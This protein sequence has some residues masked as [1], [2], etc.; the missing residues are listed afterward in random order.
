MTSRRVLSP[1]SPTRARLHTRPHG[2]GTSTP[3]RKRAR[4]GPRACG[5]SGAAPSA[6]TRSEVLTRF[7]DTRCK[8]QRDRASASWQRGFSCGG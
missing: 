2:R 8:S 3:P 5:A 7:D 1:D 4:R 6:A